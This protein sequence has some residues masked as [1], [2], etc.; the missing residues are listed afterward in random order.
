MNWV[1]SHLVENIKAK[2]N[3]NL[4]L[5][6]SNTTK[7]VLLRMVIYSLSIPYQVTIN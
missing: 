6:D 2:L 3:W 4:C 5:M 1:H 7:I